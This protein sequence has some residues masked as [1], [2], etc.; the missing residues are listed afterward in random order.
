MSAQST[1][2]GMDFSPAAEQRN[3]MFAQSKHR[4][5][6]FAFRALTVHGKNSSEF[7]VVCIAV[8]SDWRELVD[9]LMPNT[10]E[11][12]WQAYRDRGE[13]PIAMGFA[14]TG[15]RAYILERLPDLRASL[16]GVCPEGTANAVVLNQGGGSVYEITAQEDKTS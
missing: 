4:L 8:D 9:L 11:A 1:P 7:I 3:E 14:N 12:Q 2:I 13:P 6:H 16:E 15:A 5:Q 10:T